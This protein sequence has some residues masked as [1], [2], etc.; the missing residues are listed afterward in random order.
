VRR[1]APVRSQ[2]AFRKPVLNLMQPEL[3]PASLD[4]M[5]PP[6]DPCRLVVRLV[7]LLDLSS[8]KKDLK[9]QG[10]PSYP[11]E[12]M[13]ALEMLSKWDGEFGSRRVEKRCKYDTRYKWV[14]KGLSPDHTTIWRFRRSL[15]EHLEELLAE[16][17]RLGKKA[18]L[19]SLG[20]ASIDGTKLPGAASQWRRF[21]KASE[22]ADRDLTEKLEGSEQKTCLAQGPEPESAEACAERSPS[23]E[24]L[25]SQIIERSKKP[26]KK[27]EALPFKDPDAR[28]LK[29]TKGEYIVGYNAQLVIDLDTGLAMAYHVTNESSDTALL[30]PTLERYLAVQGELPSELLADAGYDSP[31]NAQVLEDLGIDACVACK[32]R[33]PLWRLDEQD[34]PICPMGHVAVHDSTYDKKGVATIR[35]RVEQCPSCPL[36]SGCL[37]RSNAVHKTLS[38]VASA[39]V[40][41]WIRQKHKAR[42]DGGKVRLKERGE[43]I[44]FGFARMKH[45]HHYRRISM[46]GLEGA[47][48]EVGTMV[49]AMNLAILSAS[50]GAERLEELLRALL[51]RFRAL[52]NRPHRPTWALLA[53]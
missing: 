24:E 22:E 29:T 16:S 42:S 20:R 11:V 47:T 9:L 50:I 17:V 28:T 40:A 6:D 10:A 36:R 51:L 30:E 52:L 19:E 14:C 33:N 31:H 43:T 2:P 35:L 1:G 23:A 32:E 27:P 46:W 5:I 34:L 12:I 13:L 49:L 37:S 38:F 48:I 8:L 15:K 21:R 7:S 53:A 25:G 45:R 44:E 4:E 26:Q 41:N 18:G 3:L 39:D